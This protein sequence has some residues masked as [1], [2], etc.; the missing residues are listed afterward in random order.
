[1]AVKTCLMPVAVG[2]V[3]LPGASCAKLAGGSSVHVQLPGC[4]WGCCNMASAPP[5]FIFI[6]HF[7]SPCRLLSLAGF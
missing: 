3:S 6:F 1:M 5:A 7:A 2:S 4:P